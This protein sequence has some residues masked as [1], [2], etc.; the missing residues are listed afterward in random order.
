[1][2][3]CFQH[4]N[5]ADLGLHYV[6]CPKVPFCVTLA[7]YSLHVSMSIS[8]FPSNINITVHNVNPFPA[9]QLFNFVRDKDCSCPDRSQNDYVSDLDTTHLGHNLLI[10]DANGCTSVGMRIT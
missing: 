2:Y 9:K 3:R 7:N 8:L 6:K 10:H 1:M 4:R 5:W